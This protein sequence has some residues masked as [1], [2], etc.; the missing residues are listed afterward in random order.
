M[1]YIWGFP[2]SL[3]SAGLLLP[4]E[5]LQADM[6]IQPYQAAI[7]HW[8]WVPVCDRGGQEGYA[9]LESFVLLPRGCHSVPAKSAVFRAVVHLCV[10]KI[11]NIVT[12][13]FS[14]EG[15]T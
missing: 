5:E 4:A 15:L 6:R 9:G 7:S 10:C 11:H 14:T 3:Q 8:R 1:R 2:Y 12:V 13:L